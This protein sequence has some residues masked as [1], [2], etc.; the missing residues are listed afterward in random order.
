MPSPRSVLPTLRR[1]LLAQP[2]LW[3]GLLLAALLAWLDPQPPQRWLHWLDLPSLAAL[4]ALLAVAQGVRESGYVQ[5]V[6]ARL[7]ARVASLRA[8]ALLLLALAAL[9][10]MFLTNDVAL[11]LVV[12]LT[13]ALAERAHL[14]RRTLVVFEALAVNAGS[15]LSPVGNPQN[16][17]LWNQSGA[18]MGA[19]AA[20]LAPTFVVLV[21]VLLAAA[22]WRFPATPLRRHRRG[23]AAAPR[24]PLLGGIALLLLAATLLLLQWRRPFLAAALV[25]AVM[26]AL[27]PSLLRRLDWMLLATLAAML[28]A[29]GHLATLPQ[30]ASL[31]QRLDGAHPLTVL[32]AGAG[33]SQLISNV[34][35]TLALR[36]AV[37]D[38]L[39]LA[40]AVN[41]GG[42]GLAIGSLASLIALRLEG[43]RRI[44]REFHAVSVPYLLLTASLLGGLWW[45]MS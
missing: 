31:L 30:V 1:L 25:L 41:V 14:P 9:L 24:R 13:L 39:R 38:P 15:A 16:L 43:S 7:L 32:A 44:W 28:L 10:A 5:D 21:A 36:H 4:L 35:A 22:W 19:F 42:A 29:L 8:L 40:A 20:A 2:L 26:G 27:R 3:L 45:L 17:L 18:S 33:L 11:F 6:A 37:A 23:P 34:P 12:P